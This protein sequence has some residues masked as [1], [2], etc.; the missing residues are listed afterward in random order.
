MEQV[1]EGGNSYRGVAT[2]MEIFSRSY[3][4]E[5]PQYNSIRNWVGRIG[6][7]ELLRTKEKRDDWIFIV[8]LTLELGKEQVLVIYGISDELWK[9]NILAEER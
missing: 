9:E 6:L 4:T 5:C 7:Y 2:T 3:Y 1:I 8:D